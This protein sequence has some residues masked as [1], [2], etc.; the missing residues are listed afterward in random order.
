MPLE[1]YLNAQTGKTTWKRFCHIYEA[2][3]WPFAVPVSKFI[4]RMQ[5]SKK[6]LEGIKFLD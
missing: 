5:W 4:I 2:A 6:C 1:S 3:L